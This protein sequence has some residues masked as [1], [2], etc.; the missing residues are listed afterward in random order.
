MRARPD[1]IA[2]APRAREL[3]ERVGDARARA[4]RDGE[5]WVGDFARAQLGGSRFA[6]FFILACGGVLVALLHSFAQWGWTPSDGLTSTLLGA[7]IAGLLVAAY[8]SLYGEPFI[9]RVL[10]IALYMPL[11]GWLL[12]NGA[13][14]PV[15]HAQRMGLFLLFPLVSAT[16]TIRFSGV[17]VVGA[18]SAGFLAFHLQD[19]PESVGWLPWVQWALAMIFGGVLRHFR[20]RLALHSHVRR[21]ELQTRVR[22]DP[23]TGLYNRNGWNELA[24]RIATEGAERGHGAWVLFFDVDRFKLINDAYGHD[25]GDKVLQ[26]LADLISQL[27]PRRSTVARMGG[28]EFVAIIASGD[29]TAATAFAEHVRAG[30]EQACKSR[31]IT[32]SA[33]VARMRPGETLAHTMKRA[34]QALYRA[35][36]AGRNRVE[37]APDQ[38]V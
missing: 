31:G 28:E 10:G 20:L 32:V 29:P 26:Q 8:V 14:D 1:A 16:L 22:T 25:A 23:L 3:L 13:T 7:G 2:L 30:F 38:P 5:P 4:A 37:V 36:G 17:M 35:K 33:G 15:S 18:A 9:L 34:D 24:P 11:L 6:H 27:S 19:H 21:M 12:A